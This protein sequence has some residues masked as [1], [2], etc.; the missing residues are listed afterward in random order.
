MKK[1][2]LL[3]FLLLII[4][5]NQN[6]MSQQIKRNRSNQQKKEDS[7]N[8]YRSDK[9]T[10]L[11]LLEAIELSGV[12]IYKYHLGPFDKK[13]KLNLTLDEY[14]DGKIIKSDTSSIENNMYRYYLNK[15]KK[16]VMYYD[17]IDQIKI[18]TKVNDTI[19][20]L[21]IST[22]VMTMLRPITIKKY[23]KESFYNIRAYIESKWA[24]NEKMPLLIYASSW[25]D[26]KYGF[27]RFCGS[28]N[29]KIG[30]KDTDELLSSSPHYYLVSYI[31]TDI[32]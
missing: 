8:Q 6:L 10:N 24:L 7:N 14:K 19:L 22:Y 16:S 4:F 23:D 13:Y 12:N 26:K 3:L 11:D 32:K 30:D 25:K 17:Y 2:H 20:S 5:V 9:I 18:F 27:Q 21:K 15:K 1:L 28:V 29:L 31:L